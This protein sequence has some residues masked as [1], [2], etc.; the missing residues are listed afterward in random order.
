MLYLFSPHSLYRLCGYKPTQNKHIQSLLCQHQAFHSIL[1]YLS[2]YQE[3]LAKKVGY[4]S[5]SSVNKIEIFKGKDVGAISYD[6]LS[7]NGKEYRFVE[8]E[9][10]PSDASIVDHTWAKCCSNY[11]LIKLFIE[12]PARHS[13]SHRGTQT[14]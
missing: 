14:E 8:E 6:N 4:K 3:E 7:I 12:K 11:D 5:R 1:L 13:Q 9:K 10:A 2:P